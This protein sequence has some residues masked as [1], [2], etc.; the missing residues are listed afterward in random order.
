MSELFNDDFDT[1]DTRPQIAISGFIK[2]TTVLYNGAV[3]QRQ[4]AT[5]W[6]KPN[7][8][9]NQWEAIANYEDIETNYQKELR[10]DSNK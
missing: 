2:A 10:R 8:T 5:V 7:P 4:G 1:Q 3:L 6:Y 9:A